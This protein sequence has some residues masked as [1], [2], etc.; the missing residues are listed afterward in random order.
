MASPDGPGHTATLAAVG[1]ALHLSTEHERL[2]EDHLALDLAGPAG[3]AL[4]AQL[5]AQAPP[6]ALEGLSLAFA[7]RARFVEDLVAEATDASVSQYVILGAGLDTF[8]YRRSDLTGRLR[9][10]EVDRPGAQAWKRAR[11]AELGVAVPAGLVFVPV[12]FEAGDVG[13]ELSRGGFDLTAT[14]VVSWIAVSQ[15]LGRGAID[16]TLRWAAQ[17]PAGSRLV[18]TYVVPPTSSRSWRRPGWRGRG[19]RRRPVESRS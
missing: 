17:L 13:S 18:L 8:A 10:Y 16:R 15:Y 19:R 1:R 2:I 7:L 5:S 6:A 14:A 3:A 4:M 9:V 11:L 12:D